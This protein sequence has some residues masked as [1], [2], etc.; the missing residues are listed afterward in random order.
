MLVHW[1]AGQVHNDVFSLRHTALDAVSSLA[2]VHWT[3]NHV[4]NDA[5]LLRK[6]RVESS[7]RNT[8]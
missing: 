5:L 2:S 7:V 8:S 3:T 6:L 1:I 4:R